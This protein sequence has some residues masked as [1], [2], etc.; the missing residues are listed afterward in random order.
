MSFVAL[1]AAY[2]N[3]VKEM[4]TAGILRVTAEARTELQP[5]PI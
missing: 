3:V 1:A 5:Q 2:E 4:F